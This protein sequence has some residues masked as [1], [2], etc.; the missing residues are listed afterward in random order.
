M[1]IGFK[2]VEVNSAE[3]TFS[4]VVLFF[5]YLLLSLVS[6]AVIYQTAA[7]LLQLLRRS[8]L[9]HRKGEK[10]PPIGIDLGTSNSAIAYYSSD[11]LYAKVIPTYI[12]PHPN[13]NNDNN[14]DYINDNNGLWKR[15]KKKTIPSLLAYH[16]P[17]NTFFPGYSALSL[18]SSSSNHNLVIDEDMDRDKEDWDKD[19]EIRGKKEER[20]G[21]G[22]YILISNLKR[23]IGRTTKQSEREMEVIMEEIKYL[24]YNIVFDTDL[25]LPSPSPLGDGQLFID[26]PLFNHN[27][28]NDNDNENDND[29]NNDNDNDHDDSGDDFNNDFKK[30]KMG[31]KRRKREEKGRKREEKGRKREEKGRKREEK[32]RKREEKGRKR[33]TAVD[34]TSRILYHLKEI[35][36]EEL[37][38][39]VKEVVITVPAYFNENQRKFTKVAGEMAGLKVLHLLS[40]PTAA[41][42]AYGLN[43]TGKK[44]V[45]VFDWGGGTLD[46]SILAL[47]DNDKRANRFQVLSTAGDCHLGGEDL[48][49]SFLLSLLLR[50]LQLHPHIPSSKHRSIIDMIIKDKKVFNRVKREVEKVKIS[51]SSSPS[52][53][54]HLPH[55]FPGDKYRG[56]DKQYWEKYQLKKEIKMEV[57]REEFEKG[58]EK[59]IKKAMEVVERGIEEAAMRKDEID[60]VIMV[61]GS[62]RIPIIRSSLSRYFNGKE[63]CYSIDP[64]LA[65]AEGAAIYSAMISPSYSLSDQVLDDTF[66]FDLIPSSISCEYLPP[67]PP[68]NIIQ[69][70]ECDLDPDWQPIIH[71]VFKRNSP[72]PIK[73]KLVVRNLYSYQRSITINIYEGDKKGENFYDNLLI[74]QYRFPIAAYKSAKKGEREIEIEFEMDKNGCL[75]VKDDT[76][77]LPPS[78]SFSPLLLFSFF[79]FFLYLFLLFLFYIFYL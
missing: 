6:T 64:E 74:G 1:S 7:Y 10:A 22:E 78:S 13:L 25:F 20:G 14:N 43:I 34:L 3:V 79:L 5:I 58:V 39:E 62:S 2:S 71:E 21:E 72:F 52:S 51:L 68:E 49:I 37:G 31:D 65:V 4:S 70:E 18:S 30:K 17:S 38:R 48:D 26:L 61:G 47:Q 73:N 33:Y 67:P 75:R 11:R 12:T 60:E 77:N 50:Y 40:E 15:K 59:E 44:N 42:L 66:L 35:A 9:F 53:S 76:I 46:V 28:N 36:E 63:L 69:K 45:M 54:F 8:F 57:S 29:N 56:G 24:P 41:A 27:N 32:G 55:L 16:P 19:R 23:L